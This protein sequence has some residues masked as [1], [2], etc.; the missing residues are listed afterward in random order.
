MTDDAICLKYDIFIG[1]VYTDVEIQDVKKTIISDITNDR[2]INSESLVKYHSYIIR[3]KIK[4][5]CS[6]SSNDYKN[7]ELLRKMR[8]PLMYGKTLQF[9]KTND[10]QK[11]NKILIAEVANVLELCKYKYQT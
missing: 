5:Y 2:Q 10:N 3:K 1:D 11:E 7:K 9:I 4:N 6:D 8:N